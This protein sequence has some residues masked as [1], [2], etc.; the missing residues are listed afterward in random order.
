MSDEFPVSVKADPDH[1][2]S[3]HGDHLFR[4]AMARVGR[5][6]V[7]EDLVQE[8]LLAALKA[9]HE[10]A[11]R[12]TERTWLVAILK[13]KTIDWLRR[14]HRVQFCTDLADGDPWLDAQFDWT[15]HWAQAPGRWGGDP[16]V[17]CEGTE[18]RRIFEDCRQN[19]PER[20]RTILSLRLL[21]DVPAEQICSALDITSANLW[22]LLHRAR[23]RLW[24]CLDKKGLAR[25]KP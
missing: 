20:L 10:F 13:R 1:W 11:G 19:L 22:T 23:V 7:A 4:H 16:A 6:D 14:V 18:F 17:L 5:R 12:S 3:E 8:T 15:R 2:L 21:D 24:N 25:G 9:V